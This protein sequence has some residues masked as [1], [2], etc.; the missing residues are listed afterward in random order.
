TGD[1]PREQA[2]VR[3]KY[4]DESTALSGNIVVLVIVLFGVRYVHLLAGYINI[5]GREPIRKLWIR[6]GSVE[7]F[8]RKVSAININCAAVKVSGVKNGGRAG[9]T[10]CKPFVYSSRIIDG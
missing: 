7:R 10:D 9:G 2:P 5:E 1:K 4:V 3:I 8:A 6:E